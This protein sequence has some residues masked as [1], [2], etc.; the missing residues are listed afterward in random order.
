ME[1]VNGGVLLA[2]EERTKEK[3]NGKEKNGSGLVV[4]EDEEIRRKWLQM[5]EE[6]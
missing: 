1:L 3:K 2:K 5:G 4:R 6:K